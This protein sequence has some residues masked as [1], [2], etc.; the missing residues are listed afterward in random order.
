MTRC[1]RERTIVGRGAGRAEVS[2]LAAGS[3]GENERLIQPGIPG[4]RRGSLA[5]GALGAHAAGCLLGFCLGLLATGQPSAADRASSLGF[6][7]GLWVG[8]G[9]PLLVD[10]CRMQARF[11]AQEP[12][13]REPLRIRDI[14]DG[15]VVFLIGP[16]TLVALV[17][18]DQM[19]VTG[20][21][22]TG[23]ARLRRIDRL[24]ADQ[25]GGLACG[26]SW[27]P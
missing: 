26:R 20:P 1:R 5:R 25:A 21:G 17:D 7:H 3:P 12:F 16:R 27:L 15:L 14:T 23:S 6:I 13:T 4:G 24:G 9:P 2:S 22:I 19:E 10:A 11:G 8:I 18:G